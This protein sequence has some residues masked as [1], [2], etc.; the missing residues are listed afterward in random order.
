MTN[1]PHNAA[2]QAGP[3]ASATAPLALWLVLLAA[4]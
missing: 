3:Q 1:K 2:T 4:Q